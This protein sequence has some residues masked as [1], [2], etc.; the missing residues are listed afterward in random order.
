MEISILF[1]LRNYLVGMTKFKEIPRISKIQKLV[2]TKKLT[3]PT[4]L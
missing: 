3:N 4:P 1:F 2:E